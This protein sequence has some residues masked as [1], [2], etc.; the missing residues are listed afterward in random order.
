MKGKHFLPFYI[1]LIITCLVNFSHEQTFLV[2]KTNE[3]R[4]NT[5]FTGDQILY[6]IRKAANGNIYFNYLDKGASPWDLRIMNYNPSGSG[7][8]FTIVSADALDLD[9]SENGTLSLSPIY[10]Y[11]YIYS[12]VIN[13][14]TYS[15][16]V[17]TMYVDA[18]PSIQWTSPLTIEAASTA[19]ITR[20]RIVRSLNHSNKFFVA[21]LKYTSGYFRVYG[22]TL[23]YD[24]GATC[25][26]P[27]ITYSLT[28][29]AIFMYYG[30][31]TNQLGL[32]LIALSAAAALDY[33]TCWYQTNGLPFTSVICSFGAEDSPPTI[34]YDVNT[35][36]PSITGDQQS[37]SMCELTGSY[38]IAIAFQV[39]DGDWNIY[40]N[41]LDSSASY[42]HT[43]SS[44]VALLSGSNAST[45]DEINPYVICHSQGD[46][47]VV[48]EANQNSAGT[49][50][51]QDIYAIAV[52]S[53]GTVLGSPLLINNTKT[54]TQ[55]LPQGM[56]LGTTYGL[57]IVWESDQNG[58]KDN[59]YRR[60]GMQ[61]CYSFTSYYNLHALNTINF[62][63]Y[64]S[65]T[66]ISIN[67]NGG[68]SNG[69]VYYN[70]GVVFATYNGLFSNFQFKSSST[71]TPAY[72]ITYKGTA[73][74][75]T[76]TA[77]TITMQPCWISCDSCD[78]TGT[79]T[80]H[81][82][83]AC[84]YA[85]APIYYAFAPQVTNC[86]KAGDTE[87][88]SFYRSPTP[89]VNGTTKWYQCSTT[90]Q[91]CSD[92]GGPAGKCTSCKTGYSP[93][94]T[95]TQYVGSNCPPAGT[96]FLCYPD[97]QYIQGYYFSTAYIQCDTACYDCTN[98]ADTTHR[99]CTSCTTGYWPV[100]VTGLTD[101]C[102]KH[103]AETNMASST[104]VVS[105]YAPATPTSKGLYP[106][107]NVSIYK[108]CNPKCYDCT[109]L[110]NG[111]DM[112]CNT[113]ASTPTP[114][115][116]KQ[117]DVYNNCYDE[118]VPILYYYLDTSGSP[119]IF[120]PCYTN[121][122]YCS[123]SGTTSNHLCTTCKQSPTTYYPVAPG[124][125]SFN[126][127]KST[128]N[129][130]DTD[131]MY[132]DLV[133]LMWKGCPTMC[134][135]CYM[136]NTTHNIYCN[137]CA[138]GYYFKQ[139]SDGYCYNSAPNVAGQP[140]YYLNS[141]LWTACYTSCATCTTSGSSGAHNCTS[142]L[143]GYVLRFSQA[144]MCHKPVEQFDFWYYS[145]STNDF[146]QCNQACQRCLDQVPKDN[147]VCSQCNTNI[148]APSTIQ[149]YPLELPT[150]P[151]TCF[152]QV[153]YPGYWLDYT[154]QAY[155]RCYLSC[156]QCDLLGTGDSTTHKCDSNKC[157]ASY[158]PLA[159]DMTMCF[160]T[161]PSKH[162]FSSNTWALCWSSCEDCS[163]LGNGLNH[164][165]NV[166]YP[167]NQPI[168]PGLAPM[169]C[170]PPPPATVPG[171]YYDSST[172]MWTQCYQ[173]CSTCSAAGTPTVNSC[174]ACNPGSAG[175][176]VVPQ[177]YPREDDTTM[178]DLQTASIS[179]YYFNTNKFSRCYQSCETCSTN[180]LGDATD[181]KCD[182]CRVSPK[183][184]HLIDQPN[185]CYL[186]T[187]IIN[188]YIF[189]TNLFSQ[190]YSGCLTCTALPANSGAIHNCIQCNTNYYPL[191][192]NKSQCYLS[193]AAVQGYFYDPNLF[194]FDSC[195]KTCKTCDIMGDEVNHHC[196]TCADGYF[197]LEDNRSLCYKNNKLIDRYVFS[198]EDL[199]FKRCFNSCYNC[200]APGDELAMNCSGCDY[201]NNYY[202]LENA[203][204]QCYLKTRII[205]GYYADSDARMFKF[206]YTSCI[207][208]SAKGDARNPNCSICKPD[209]DCTP[210]EA[211]LYEGK[212]LAKCPDDLVFD[213]VNLTCLNC[214]SQTMVRLDSQCVSKCPEQY[215]A[216][217]YVC[218]S[219]A[220]L[221]KIWSDEDCKTR[222]PAGTTIKDGLCMPDE[223][224]A[225][226]KVIDTGMSSNFCTSLFCD[227]GGACSVQFYKA[228]CACLDK[229]TGANCQL[230]N[231]QGTYN[232]LLTLFD[233]F[234]TPLT[235]DNYQQLEDIMAAVK[236]N[237]DKL[238]SNIV[239][240]LT[241]L[242]SIYF[243]TF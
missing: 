164:Q 75:S 209:M 92:V 154:N 129:S 205:D 99:Y 159:E 238:N 191:W 54:G 73:Y 151:L 80:D 178:C 68:T 116:K 113:C 228:V 117:G 34:T 119:H 226:K 203:T 13:Y 240:K 195:Y 162:F 90:C 222:C 47:V 139:V 138:T 237:P 86:Y 180:G 14:N 58:D 236:Q 204:T 221:G 161:R 71:P 115:A 27:T 98:M 69:S 212:C 165:C 133:A 135:T 91:T 136:D 146:R 175:P 16:I 89:Y 242:C 21:Y 150:Y 141:N 17:T 223:T 76:D 127:W 243:L 42:K 188:G 179:N 158:Y 170:Y 157:T 235:Q 62:T 6:T 128:G 225:A 201:A 148:I 31:N 79:T 19:Q 57:A 65:S 64:G 217:N 84:Y 218:T 101:N 125:G 60:I 213:E 166:C 74:T 126:C 124:T 118:S 85:S 189:T 97:S 5:L 106:D 107:T 196:T 49:G 130:P 173:S 51:L 152:N 8:V 134:S 193:T 12:S 241:N 3:L 105:P 33:C 230:Y 110:D 93:K 143:T 37:P 131:Y 156:D 43:F 215:T 26:A 81:Y 30:G 15:N 169:S 102:F 32:Q 186:N 176:P 229:Y 137:L 48:Y 211:I 41:I 100:N 216:I 198:G 185:M 174:V 163:V 87:I 23:T 231:N 53:D 181:H 233:D 200:S 108:A 192:D 190:C 120:K 112:F 2:T 109:G 28:P 96:D 1:F 208:C 206:C 88:T 232:D 168:A 56:D 155:K 167:G 207:T 194:Q 83:L 103:P 219:C 55:T 184:Y 44:H 224:V 149:Y 78:A 63:S 39:D 160:N 36:M 132:F 61:M 24:C 187:D 114:Y 182:S 9:I 202:P 153:H 197:P 40:F 70:G 104:M 145:S 52:T 183:Y 20:N 77:C 22:T 50:I 94:C 11:I 220:S 122:D 210:C 214:Q 234:S 35:S 172:N 18:T 142:C 82:C 59:Y 4:V 147:T 46:F 72:T 29:D 177:Y 121:C 239:D 25:V 38:D 144:S 199:M 7:S 45:Y 67:Y 66:S 111:T 10:N 140:G 123:G 227:N 95:Q 171:Y